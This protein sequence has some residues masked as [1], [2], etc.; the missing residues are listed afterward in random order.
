M[1]HSLC[2]MVE[3]LQIWNLGTRISQK[4][5]ELQL[6]TEPKNLQILKNI[7]AAR[8]LC[9]F[10][11]GV[12]DTCGKFLNK[13]ETALMRYSGAWGKL[14]HEKNLKS[15]IL[16]HCPFKLPFAWTT[17]YLGET[18]YSCCHSLPTGNYCMSH[19]HDCESTKRS[20]PPHTHT[21]VT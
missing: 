5:A 13:F 7:C 8:H 10:F 21:L 14:I 9:K 16:W 12:N 4:F 18:S 17:L 15:K 19:S 6:R 20:P 1:F 11:T 2:L 3:N